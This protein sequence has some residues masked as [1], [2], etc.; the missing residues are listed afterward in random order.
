MLQN[1]VP[2]EELRAP[3]N[4]RTGMEVQR[5]KSGV[6]YGQNRVESFGDAWPCSWESYAIGK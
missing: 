2:D 5:E 4:A 6:E 1:E 3:T